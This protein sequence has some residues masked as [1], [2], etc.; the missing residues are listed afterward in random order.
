M[1]LQRTVLRAVFLRPKQY[2]VRPRQDLPRR[3]L[4]KHTVSVRQLTTTCR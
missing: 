1:L 3:Y 4:S 2:S